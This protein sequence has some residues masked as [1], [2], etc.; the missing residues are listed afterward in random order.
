MEAMPKAKAAAQKAL[1]ID[2]TL[3]EAHATLGFVKSFY[4]WEWSKAEYEYKRALELN[5]GYATGH[6]WYSGLLRALGQFERA[7]EEMRRAQELDPLSAAIGRDFGRIFNSMR[8]QGQAIDQYRKT[9]ELNPSFASGYLHLGLAYA[10]KSQYDE[11]LAAFQK[12]RVVADDNP[13]IVAGLGHCY[14][15][16][17]NR[18][19]AGE[20]LGEL[21]QQSKRRH[22]PAIAIALLYIGLGE[23]DEAFEWLDNAY[24]D[25]D[26]WLTWLRVDPVFDGLRQD[27]RFFSL[28]KKVHLAAD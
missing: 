4:D 15:L 8:Q 5:P 1:E 25:H 14:A 16:M 17:G 11:A 18:V 9:L 10:Q 21:L 26:A 3:G 20:L 13:L 6:H 22:I 28:L 2:G 27:P 24:K 7:L 12:G 23:T 19:K